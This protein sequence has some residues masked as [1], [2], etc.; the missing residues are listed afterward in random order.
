MEKMNVGEGSGMKLWKNNLAPM[1]D[2][3]GMV[4]QSEW[5]REMKAVKETLVDEMRV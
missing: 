2:W 3:D 4:D 1:L 5:N